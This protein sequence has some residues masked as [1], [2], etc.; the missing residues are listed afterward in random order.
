MNVSSSLTYNYD[1]HRKHKHSYVIIRLNINFT[2]YLPEHN[3]HK[4]FTVGSLGPQ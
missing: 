3:L 2:F 4:H 1:L